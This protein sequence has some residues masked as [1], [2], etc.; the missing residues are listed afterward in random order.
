MHL[1]QND[2]KHNKFIC[3]N[4]KFIFAESFRWYLH[5]D[6]KEQVWPFHWCFIVLSIQLIGTTLEFTFLCALDTWYQKLLTFPSPLLQKIYIYIYISNVFAYKIVVKLGT[7]THEFYSKI[8]EIVIAFVP[9][10]TRQ[11]MYLLI[12]SKW[13][14]IHN[15]SKQSIWIICQV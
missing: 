15:W 6:Q 5:R 9:Q 11:L 3:K 7:N 14:R 12:D 1:C 10:N 13:S 2:C 4:T 8:F